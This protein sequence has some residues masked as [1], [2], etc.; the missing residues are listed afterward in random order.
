MTDHLA[1]AKD[2][3]GKGEEFYRKA[4]EEIKAAREADFA[5]TWEQVA[6]RV[7]KSGTWCRRLVQWG[8]SPQSTADTPFAEESG[9][10]AQ[11]HARSVLRNA[12]PEQIAELLDDPTVRAKVSQAQQ[13]AGEKVEQRSEQTFRESIGDDLADN[14]ALEKELRDAEAQ[15]FA[16]R[17]ALIGTLKVLHPNAADLPDAWREEFLR[18]VDDVG[19]KVDMLRSLLTGVTDDELDQLLAGEKS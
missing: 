14:L 15:L 9:R 2:Y 18:T 6:E 16:A 4:A 7:G 8:T 13:I 19:Q 10:V 5:L 3:I 11:R 1:R 17:R 12:P